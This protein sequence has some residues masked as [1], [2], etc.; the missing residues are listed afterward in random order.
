MTCACE[1]C[2]RELDPAA[3]VKGIETAILA[4]EMASR[5]K[6]KSGGRNGGRPSKNGNARK[7][8]KRNV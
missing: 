4:R 7:E 3:V 1:H 6:V 8:V 2:K 5:R